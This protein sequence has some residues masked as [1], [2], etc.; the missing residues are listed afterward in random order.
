MKQIAFNDQFRE[1]TKI[2]AL[3]IIRTVSPKKYSDAISVIRKQ[4]FRSATSVA[5][6]FRSSCRARS[7]K[8]LYAK[9][10]IVVEESD[11]VLFWLELLVD[12]KM[13]D[14]DQLQSIQKDALEVLKV[15]SSYKHRVGQTL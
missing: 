15:M 1:K 2:L 4:L 9:L 12:G 10:C 14:A 3:D 7:Q 11:E 5:A 6:N 13:M 8:E